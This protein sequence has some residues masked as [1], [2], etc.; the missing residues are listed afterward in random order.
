[1]RYL[2]HFLES[3][4]IDQKRKDAKLYPMKIFLAFLSCTL[5]SPPE[6]QFPGSCVCLQYC[7]HLHSHIFSCKSSKKYMIYQWLPRCLRGKESAC[8]FRRLRR[9]GF[10]PWKIP[11]RR[12]WQPTSAFLPGKSHGQ[13]S[14]VGSS[15]WG[16]KESDIT[17][18]MSAHTQ[19][20]IYVICTFLMVLSTRF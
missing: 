4:H 15:P 2:A 19:H 6:S 18:Q 8:Q 13:R 14:L 17:E 12:K 5:N 10:N 1:M 11:W 3:M 9:C 16:R 20:D 7:K